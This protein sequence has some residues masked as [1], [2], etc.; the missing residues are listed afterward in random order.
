MAGNSPCAAES[1]LASSSF[2][3]LS[4]HCPTGL[5][6]GPT[7]LGEFHPA[8]LELVRGC[9]VLI[10]D[11]Q[12]LDEELAERA[13]FGHSAAGY[14]VALAEAASVPSVLLFHHDPQRT[15]DAMD[16]LV[17]RYQG[18]HVAVDAARHGA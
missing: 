8:A 17:A 10:H 1:A 14:P 18:R 3:Y 5:G 16:A 15:D 11:S 12:Y 13:D 6:P 2:A 4:D 7:G 9:D